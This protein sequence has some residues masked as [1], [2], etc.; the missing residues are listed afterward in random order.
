VTSIET[1]TNWLGNRAPPWRGVAETRL[2]L[3]R[4]GGGVDLVV[5]GREG[6]L[7]QR[8]D[9]I[10]IQR[11]DGQPAPLAAM[12]LSWPCGTVKAMSMGSVRVMVAM[13]LVSDGVT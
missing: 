5:E 6:A 1:L 13:P 10:L 7:R 9:A 2:G 11:G 12:A 8:R 3:H 4:A